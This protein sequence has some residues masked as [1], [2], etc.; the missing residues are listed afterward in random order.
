VSLLLQKGDRKIKLG[1]VFVIE[2]NVLYPRLV[3]NKNNLK[4]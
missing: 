2:I 4:Q 3:V 1:L